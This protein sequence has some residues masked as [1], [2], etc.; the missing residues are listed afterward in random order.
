M[1]HEFGVKRRDFLKGAGATVAAVAGAEL[2]SLSVLRPA[3][4]SINPLSIIYLNRVSDLLFAMARRANKEAG[5]DDV[6]WVPG[7]ST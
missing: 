1:H 5:V 2:L 6:P 7:K 3:S 4:A